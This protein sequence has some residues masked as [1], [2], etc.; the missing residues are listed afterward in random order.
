MLNNVTYMCMEMLNN[1]TYLCMENLPLT[2][3][4]TIL[5]V[6][7]IQ[8]VINVLKNYMSVNNFAHYTDDMIESIRYTWL[9]LLLIVIIVTQSPIINQSIIYTYFMFFFFPGFL[10]G[11]IV[12]PIKDSRREYYRDKKLV[13]LI[14]IFIDPVLFT[15][16]FYMT[17]LYCVIDTPVIIMRKIRKWSNLI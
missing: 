14:K 13:R 1:V 6:I 16:L 12:L 5:V 9:S 2:I 11:S 10:Y 8:F 15:M 17:I 4:G 7:I 3:A